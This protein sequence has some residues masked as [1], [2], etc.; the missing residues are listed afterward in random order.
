MIMNIGNVMVM[1]CR[2][3]GLKVR[4]LLCLDLGCSHMKRND[5]GK[6]HSL[7]ASCGAQIQNLNYDMLKHQN[8]S[9]FTIVHY[10][11]QCLLRSS[12]S[13]LMLVPG[14]QSV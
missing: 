4:P 8:C 10:E 2:M 5:D 11:M 6:V 14:D 7:I 1:T 9:C 13:I 12:I 3:C